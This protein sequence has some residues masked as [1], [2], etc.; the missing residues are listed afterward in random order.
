MRT[1]VRVLPA[2]LLLFAATAQAEDLGAGLKKCSGISDSLQRLVWYDNL[3]KRADGLSAD[4][5]TSPQPV[6]SGFSGL[7]PNP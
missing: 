7:P 5:T 4:R 2:V 1:L 3:A 6:V